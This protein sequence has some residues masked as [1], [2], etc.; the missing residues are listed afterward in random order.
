MPT[1]DLS[2]NQT[3]TSTTA[4]PPVVQ[5]SVPVQSAVNPPMPS[6]PVNP[7]PMPNSGWNDPW[8]S[9][10]GGG[11]QMQGDPSKRLSPQDR[12]TMIEN[13]FNEI[14]GRKPDTR[15]INYYKYS[16]LSE[17]EVKKQL[18][19][20][21]EHKQLLQDGRDYKKQKERTL[22]AETRV[23]VLEGQIKDQIE[24]FKQLTNLLKEKNKYIQELREKLN[25]ALNTHPFK[26]FEIANKDRVEQLQT[27]EH[28]TTTNTN[29]TFQPKEDANNSLIKRI[30]KIISDML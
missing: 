4:N 9:P 13:V 28:F 20:G 8:G 25:I 2:N 24:E 1:I 29:T 5:P 6:Q 3:S 26:S 22:Q 16:T 10:W 19:T 11:N 14:L 27:N 18:I 30:K 15:D 17:E 21:N 23:K 7:M 12:V